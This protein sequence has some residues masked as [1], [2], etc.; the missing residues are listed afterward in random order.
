VD[1]HGRQ[2]NSAAIVAAIA[3]AVLIVS[4][5]LAWE[6]SALASVSMVDFVTKLSN[7]MRVVDWVM[8]G[9]LMVGSVLAL[10]GASIR[11]LQPGPG[12]GSAGLA[13]G[14]F[15]AA[16]G[17]YAI[18]FWEW[19]DF[20]NSFSYTGVSLGIGVWLGCVAVVVG[21]IAA[22]VD[23]RS[24]APAASFQAGSWA[25][26][27]TGAPQ[28]PL[29]WSGNAQPPAPVAPAWAAPAAPGWA[30]SGSGRLTVVESGHSSTL[31]VNQGEQVLVGRD[32]DAKVRVSDPRVSRRH[33]SIQRSGT[34]WVVRDLGA[35]N[36]TRLLSASGTAQTIQGEVRLPSGQLL[37]GD[38]LVTL[39][40]TGA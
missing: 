39:F 18:W 7:Y 31:V 37:I 5:F 22:T 40:P 26:Q 38:V 33:A 12:R 2:P 29:G 27:A 24:I 19:S 35:T 16:L 13:V 34:D 30:S 28:A 21:I 4:F 17:G 20:S 36:P 3:A 25:P 15:L 9:L 32:V 23:L 8:V 10:A 1:S 14:G 11:A 6:S